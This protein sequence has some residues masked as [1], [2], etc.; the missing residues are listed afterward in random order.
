[1]FTSDPPPLC[2]ETLRR[3]V[4]FP[5]RLS[6]RT[7]PGPA[8]LSKV[9]VVPGGLA[10]GPAGWRDRE[11]RGRGEEERRDNSFDLFCPELRNKQIPYG[12]YA[13]VSTTS[14]QPT[15]KNWG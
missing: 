14:Q 7:L 9:N 3:Q 5:E 1:M 6:G 8:L 13:N 2:S 12:D 10:L 4:L 11:R 15:R